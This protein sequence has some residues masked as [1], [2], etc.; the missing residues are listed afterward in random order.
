MMAV[1]AARWAKEG[2]TGPGEP[3]EGIAGFCDL[4]GVPP[5]DLQDLG[6]PR[7]GLSA[8]EATGFKVYPAEYSAQGPLGIIAE[9]RPGLDVGAIEAVNIALPWG[10]WHEIGGGQGDRDAK[11]NP[12]TRETADHSLPYLVAVA[13]VDGAITPE[14]FS[15]ER[16]ADP[17]LRLLMR[18]I[19]VV[20]DP[21][22]TRTHAGEL[23]RWPS[24]VEIVLANGE[25]LRRRA[26]L[27]KGHPL[28]PLT[29]AELEAKYLALAE[30]ALPRARARA[31]LDTLWD[32]ERVPDI[33]RLTD[34]FRETGSLDRA[35]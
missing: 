19:S 2:L 31:L 7:D 27:P 17:R 21:E 5:F 30:G 11:W 25:R 14:S 20:E 4:L 16:I 29:D 26:D 8:V 13:L 15:D 18:R 33:N 24:T 9:L 3:F 23:P 12:T 1:L 6:Q 34:Q 32:L 28:D 22:L 10:G 35:A